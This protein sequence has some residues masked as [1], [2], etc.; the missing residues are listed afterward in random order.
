MMR[1]GSSPMM[2]VAVTASEPVAPSSGGSEIGLSSSVAGSASRPPRT[3][4]PLLDQRRI[5]I[6]ERWLCGSNTSDQRPSLAC[7]PSPWSISGSQ[8][9]M[10]KR[11]EAYRAP[12]ELL[13]FERRWIETGHRYFRP[14]RG[15][16]RLHLVHVCESGSRWERIHLLFRDYLRAQPRVAS[17]IRG[18]Q[19]APGREARRSGSSTTTQ[20]PERKQRRAAAECRGPSREGECLARGAPAP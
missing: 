7:R 8:S 17:E 14:P 2:K 13:G 11:D 9:P 10:S 5:W 15:T 12:I 4:A 3:T 19:A 18:T 1:L 16:P 20:R 6:C